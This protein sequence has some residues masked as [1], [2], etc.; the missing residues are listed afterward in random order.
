[1]NKHPGV[2]YRHYRQLRHQLP[3][4]QYL[5]LSLHQHYHDRDACRFGDQASPEHMRQNG[6]PRMQ[7]PRQKG[8]A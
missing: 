6:F 8:Q 1:M 5:Q 7:E 4:Q 3:T 2:G